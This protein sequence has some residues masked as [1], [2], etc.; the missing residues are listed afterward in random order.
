M[1]SEFT[2]IE[3]KAAEQSKCSSK[4]NK[5]SKIAKQTYHNAVRSQI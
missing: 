1:N 3:T 2:S 5:T 4:T